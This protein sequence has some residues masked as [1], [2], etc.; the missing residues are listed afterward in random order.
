MNYA[1]I[2]CISLAITVVLGSIGA[3]AMK[4]HLTPEAF[5]SWDTAVKYQIYHSLG[6][7]MLSIAGRVASV[8][9]NVHQ[10][11]MHLIALGMIGFCLSLYLR[12][13]STVTGLDFAWLGPVAPVG[14]LLFIAGWMLAAFSFTGIKAGDLN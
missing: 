11:S 7:L 6:L 8:K 2:A 1:R 14:G 4:P 13:S 12:S 3:H 5:N 9:R 10:W